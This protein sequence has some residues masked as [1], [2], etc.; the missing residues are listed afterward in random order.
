MEEGRQ[1]PMHKLCRSPYCPS[2]IRSAAMGG[3]VIWTDGAG[4]GKQADAV[5]RE[6]GLIK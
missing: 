4:D 1:R 5:F 3:Q 2:R 6:E